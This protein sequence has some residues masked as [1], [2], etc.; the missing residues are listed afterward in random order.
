MDLTFRIRE[1]GNMQPNHKGTKYAQL[2]VSIRWEGL[3][4]S[5]G[6]IRGGLSEEVTLDR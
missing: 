6:V 5:D 1:E 2:V 3:F 4:I